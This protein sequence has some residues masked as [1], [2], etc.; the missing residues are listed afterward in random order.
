[1]T[2]GDI[3]RSTVSVIIPSHNRPELLADAVSSVMAQRHP[4]QI[5]VVDDGSSPP[6]AA[7]GVLARGAVTI[8]R[9]DTARGPSRARNRGLDAATGDFVAF[10]DDDDRWLPGKLTA[11][12]KAFDAHDT[13]IGAVAHK[14]GYRAPAGMPATGSRVLDDPLR[15]FG[16]HQTPHPDSLV[17]RRDIA[18]KVRFAEDLPAAEDVDFAIELGRITKLVLLDAVLAV[19]GDDGAPSA[20]G[21]EKRIAARLQLKDRHSDVLGADNAARSFYHVR[22]GHLQRGVSRPK[23]MVSFLTA[24]RHRPTSATAWRGLLTTVLP[25]DLTRRLSLQRR[26]GGN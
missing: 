12:L 19:H 22:L 4:V 17:I 18:D 9:N 25:E 2:I 7:S 6:V 14:T 15:H 20:I 13:D 11:C 10:L 3:G 8:L 26:T 16:T 23:A 5:L 1:M 21:L 24:I